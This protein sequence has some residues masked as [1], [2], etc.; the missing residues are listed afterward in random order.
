[1]NDLVKIH[2]YYIYSLEAF[3][4]VFYR[5]IDLVTVTAEEA[6]EAA[7]AAAAA[8]LE[9]EGA[10]AENIPEVVPAEEDGEL[11]DNQLAARCVVLLNSI[12]S[13]VFNYVRRGVFEMDKMTVATLLTLRIAVND[14]KFIYF[15]TSYFNSDH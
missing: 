2:T 4:T 9:V 5:G 15:V 11:T 6:A 3:T 7:A 13:T 12:T 10:S 8:A 1:M 14:G